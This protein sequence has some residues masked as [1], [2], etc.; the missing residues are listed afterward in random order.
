VVLTIIHNGQAFSP[1]DI[2][3]RF[4]PEP[5]PE[6]A[7]LPTLLEGLWAALSP[8]SNQGSRHVLARVSGAQQPFLAAWWEDRFQGV[9]VNPEDELGFAIETLLLCEA[10][11]VPEACALR[12]CCRVD[13]QAEGVDAVDSPKDDR[14]SAQTVLSQDATE[15]PNRATHHGTPLWNS[16]AA[17]GAQAKAEAQ[18]QTWLNAPGVVERVLSEM[19][20]ITWAAW[21]ARWQGQISQAEAQYRQHVEVRWA[22]A[23]FAGEHPSYAILPAWHREQMPIYL[24]NVY[25]HQDQNAEWEDIPS[26]DEV[27][28]GVL[29]ACALAAGLQLQSMHPGIPFTYRLANKVEMTED[30]VMHAAYFRGLVEDQGLDDE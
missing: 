11:P 12:R 24:R 15:W 17:V 19:Q 26:L 21:N 5:D 4:D 2:Y 25:Y 18:G 20:A 23:I 10:C 27:V 22:T 28:S 30:V 29:D 14:P 3:R 13:Q 7:R 16:L 8:V 9:E 1:S 6:L